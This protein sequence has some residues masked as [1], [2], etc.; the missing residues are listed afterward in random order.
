MVS[1][2]DCLIIDDD[3]FS[4]FDF[5]R[6]WSCC[7]V[8]TPDLLGFLLALAVVVLTFLEFF[9]VSFSDAS[10]SITSFI[11]SLKRFTFICWLL[12]K[13]ELLLDCFST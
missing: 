2:S 5:D 6:C 11:N 3:E 13:L 4:S 7:L 8:L 9:R 12:L 1:G 10:G